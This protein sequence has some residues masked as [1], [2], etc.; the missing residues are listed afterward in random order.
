MV[1]INFSFINPKEDKIVTIR[2]SELN[3][4]KKELIIQL[5][6]IEEIL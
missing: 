5:I 4:P 3:K 1:K 2:I 6:L